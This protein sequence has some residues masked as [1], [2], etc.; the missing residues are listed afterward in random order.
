MKSTIS[1]QDIFGLIIDKYKL[2][3]IRLISFI[4]KAI[5]AIYVAV[6]SVLCTAL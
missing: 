6:Q 5:K 1:H 3:Y 2:F 4:S